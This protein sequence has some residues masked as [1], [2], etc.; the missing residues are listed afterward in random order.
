MIISAGNPS[1]HPPP[2]ICSATVSFH[3]PTMVAVQNTNENTI[4]IMPHARLYAGTSLISDSVTSVP[5]QNHMGFF[6]LHA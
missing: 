5:G 2:I 3:I 4:H 1:R 6:F